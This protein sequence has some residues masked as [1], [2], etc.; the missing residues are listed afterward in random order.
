[1][2]LGPAI[3]VA[4]CFALACSSSEP[5]VE[6]DPE[7]GFV[8]DEG[9]EDDFLSLTAR[10]YIVT[11]T[12]R[13]VV[14]EGQGEARA[15]ELIV[16]KHTSI[17]WFLNQ[18]LVDKE[19]EGAHKD[20]NADY[21]GF[22]A[23]VKDGAFKDLQLVQRNATTWEFK[24]EQ[25]IAGH[26]D[27]MR[28]LPLERGNFNV[29][30]GKPTNAEME[31]DVE[32]YRKDPWNAWDPAKVPATKKETITFSIKVAP[33]STDGWWDYQRLLED[34]ELTVDVHYGYDYNKPATH[35]TDP[36]RLY[37]FLIDRGFTSPVRSYDEYTRASAPLTKK[38]QAGGRTVTVKVKIFAGRAGT[39][40][41]PDTDAGGKA[42]E[43]D[44][45]ESLASKD[46]IVYSGHS[47]SLYG[48]AL[49]NWDKT[50]EGDL[51]DS[52]LATARL[53][54]G[55]YQIVFAEGCNTY[56]LGNTL[57]NNP[58]KRGKDIDVIS[59]TSFS[60]SWAPVEDFLRRLIE[61]DSKARLRPRTMTATIADLDLYTLDEPAPTM[62]G[63]HGIDDNPK[64]HP[65]ANTELMCSSCSANA[66][67][68]GTG[69]SCITVG[70]VSGKRCAPACTTDAACGE[71]FVC[72]KVASAST[73]SIYG[74]YCV[75]ANRRCE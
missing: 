45:L 25:L 67:C 57:M 42:L 15:R 18:Y 40:N 27:L 14:E 66:D 51:D 33:E 58:S 23:M 60:V 11:G 55:K 61:L 39:S 46:V 74:S 9:K 4:T 26:K 73:A 37:S 54:T 41:D 69:N 7:D 52:E 8:V 59:T 21:G 36:P 43:A 38:I 19:K 20:A 50:S 31:G 2:R 64:L 16:L 1:M 53:A 71:G 3:H 35:V 29:E 48:F 13:V 63:I 12:A 62:Y 22:S 5:V 34:G 28:R 70:A 17:T 30:I 49:A 56:M 72:K 6:G 68:G 47:G 65:F 75:P 24:F 32:W 10:E 44:M